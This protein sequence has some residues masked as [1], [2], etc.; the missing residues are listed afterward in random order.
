[1]GGTAAIWIP[2][3][4][5]LMAVGYPVKGL[6]LIGWGAGVV[7]TVDNFLRPYL[8]SGRVQMHTLL[9]FFSVFGGIQVFG[10]LGLFVGP[11]VLAV[12]S[13]LLSLLRDESRNWQ[14]LWLDSPGGNDAEPVALP[15]GPPTGIEN[16]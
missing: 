10:F 2:A 11:V 6:I 13:T 14:Q 4:I 9:I 15:D 16:R 5:Y 3:S 8:I 1:M 12:T 7:G